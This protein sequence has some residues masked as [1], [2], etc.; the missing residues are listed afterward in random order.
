MSARARRRREQFFT[1]GVTIGKAMSEPTGL[2]DLID[3]LIPLPLAAPSQI[4]AD[5]LW[6]NGGQQAEGV[7]DA[8]A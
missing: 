4:T 6:W 7:N 1:L 5:Q 2:K 8:P 3:Q